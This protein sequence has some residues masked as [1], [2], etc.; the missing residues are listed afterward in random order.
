LHIA[1]PHW[2]YEHERQPR[3]SQTVPEGYVLTVGHH[4]HLPQ[5]FERRS[6]G[7]LVA[8]SL[9]NFVTGK[10]LPV[11]GEGALLKV[12]IASPDDG[13][14]KIV[15]AHFR[16]IDLDRDR[17]QCR[18]SLRKPSSDAHAEAA[19]EERSPS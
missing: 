1:L 8:W 6:N 15:R 11:L 5:P 17:H 19:A 9:G 16:E 3:P 4:T 10:Q 13:P 7:Q 14:P 18:V 12:G 2:G